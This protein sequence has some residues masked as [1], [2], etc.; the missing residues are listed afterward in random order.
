MSV[1]LILSARR[2]PIGKFQGALGDIPAAELGAIAI[3]AALT[4]PKM[5]PSRAHEGIPFP[6]VAAIGG[7][8]ATGLV[9]LIS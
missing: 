1:S 5:T 2:T 8:C 9:M 6:A 4:T 7:A 3:D